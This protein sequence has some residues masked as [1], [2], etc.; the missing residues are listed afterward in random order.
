[1]FVPLLI[2]GIPTHTWLPLVVLQYS[3]EA[4]QHS[5]LQWRYGP[6]YG[7]MVSPAFHAFHHSAEARHHNRNFGKIFVLWDRLF[8]TAVPDL[9]PPRSFGVEGL[10]PAPSLAEQLVLPFRLIYRSARRRLRGG[11]RD[12]PP[13][14]LPEAATLDI[15]TTER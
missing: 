1:M 8:G 3:F 7:V 14:G 12:A 10:D 13:A 4:V 15:V 5:A 9:A 11:E 6:L 2:L